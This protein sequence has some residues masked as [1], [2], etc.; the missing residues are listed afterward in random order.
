LRAS[1]RSVAEVVLAPGGSDLRRVGR[2]AASARYDTEA[3]SEAME[4]FESGG[5]I[6]ETQK[7]LEATQED[8]D[9]D[10]AEE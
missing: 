8:S 2:A 3:A 10:S 1:N 5:S 9:R 7:V 6:A 4:E